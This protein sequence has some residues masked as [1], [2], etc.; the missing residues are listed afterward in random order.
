MSLKK[1]KLFGTSS[2]QL[3]Q[4][5]IDQFAHLF[6]KAEEWDGFSYEPMP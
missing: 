5:V 6:N 1:K 4:M 2:E 3:D